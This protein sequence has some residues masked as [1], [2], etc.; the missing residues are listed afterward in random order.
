VLVR[1]GIDRLA[2]AAM[3]REVGLLVAFDVQ[4]PDP[5]LAVDRH[6]AD[7]AQDAV[8]VDLKRPRRRRVDTEDR[9]HCAEYARNT[10]RPGIRPADLGISVSASADRDPIT[11][12]PGDDGTPPRTGDP[13]DEHTAGRVR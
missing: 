10:G 12:L 9:R 7:A 3:D 6:L 13:R 4:T 2:E 1:I 5:A 11:T 8:S